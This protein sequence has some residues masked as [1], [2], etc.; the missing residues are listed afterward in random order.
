MTTTLNS[1][2]W[3]EIKGKNGNFAKE[4]ENYL[5]NNSTVTK[6]NLNNNSIGAEGA[7]ALATAL[8]NNSTVTV[9]DL[10]NNSI[11]P[12]GNASFA[13][14][15]S[16]KPSQHKL[17]VI[18]LNIRSEECL[19]LLGLSEDFSQ[20]SD[21]EV[22]NYL[23]ETK[24]KSKDKDLPVGSKVN[25]ITGTSRGLPS[26]RSVVIVSNYAFHFKVST[27]NACLFH[28]YSCLTQ[29]NTT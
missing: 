7:K 2:I 23:R 4:L 6:I 11:G 18:G 19:R 9:I 24:P 20:K 14:L 17:K 3:K 25:Y 12:E 16:S 1:D 27:F 29:H 13:Y 10:S 22:I 21:E 15:L 28:C 8:Q 5:A 26:L